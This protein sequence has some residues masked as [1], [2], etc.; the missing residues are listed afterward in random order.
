M[1]PRIECKFTVNV[2]ILTA[3]PPPAAGG[4]RVNQ[5]HLD[6][7]QFRAIV[8]EIINPDDARFKAVVIEVLQGHLA[9]VFTRVR[10]AL[11]NAGYAD[12]AEFVRDNFG[13]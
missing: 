1:P 7:A 12:A 11:E 10:T 9:D 8:E 13:S 2:L 6:E 3:T 4:K 5:P